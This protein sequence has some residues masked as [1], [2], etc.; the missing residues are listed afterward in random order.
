MSPE[1]S[2]GIANVVAN[3]SAVTGVAATESQKT[4]C[5][6]AQAVTIGMAIAGLAVSLL[7]GGTLLAGG[8]LVPQPSAESLRAEAVAYFSGGALVVAGA[9]Y[10]FRV[11]LSSKLWQQ[12]SP[13]QGFVPTPAR[14]FNFC[15]MLCTSSFVRNRELLS[16]LCFALAL[17]LCKTLCLFPTPLLTR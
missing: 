4:S 6:R 9:L 11:F 1:G 13:V 10:G 8:A 2:R 16:T 17:V 3:T 14:P 12:N 5:C 7:S 15:A